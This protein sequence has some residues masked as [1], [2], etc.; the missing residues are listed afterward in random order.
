MVTLQ[1]KE[2]CRLYAIV[3][4]QGD[5]MKEVRIVV[6][7]LGF[8]SGM[9][10]AGTRRSIEADAPW[11]RTVRKFCAGIFVSLSLALGLAPV[12]AE[13]ERGFLG[14]SVQVDGEGFFLNPTLRSATIASVSASSPAARAGIAPK[15]RIVEVEGHAVA[16]AKG[17]DLEPL[18]KKAPGQSLR[19][20]L[21]RANGEEY[22]V[23]LVAVARPVKP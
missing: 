12:A 23:T 13:E 20:K 1:S 22:E 15:D 6:D 11:A 18:L 7:T 4:R 17:N 9:R 16:G 8:Q 19:L 14:F 5:C 2:R 10:R 3:Y 21:K